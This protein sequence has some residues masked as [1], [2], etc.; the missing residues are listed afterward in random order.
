MSYTLKL[1]D[2]EDASDAQR[3][4]AEQR[5]RT[6]LEDALGD[7]AL[8]APMYSMYLKLRAVYGEAPDEDVLTAAQREVFDQWQAAESAAITAA[9]GPNRYMGEPQFEIRIQSA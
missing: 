9:F 4:A 2:F 3:Q 6:A 1:Y 7:A 8:V 5:F